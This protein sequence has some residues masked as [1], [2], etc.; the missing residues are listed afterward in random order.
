MARVVKYKGH[1]E[2]A[3]K[4]MPLEE[5]IELIPSRAR[6]L[7]KR[8]ERA[9]LDDYGSQQLKKLY[10]KAR[11]V[12]AEN[13]E[14]VMKTHAREAG[15]IN[16]W[17]GLKFGVHNGKIFVPVEVTIDKLGHRLGE[18]SHGTRRVA[19]SGAGVGATRGS[20]FVPLK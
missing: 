11:K 14:T 7:L 9:K 17:L 4:V 16:D 10:K 6:R 1:D 13:P 5:F 12:Q 19:H 18:Y 2:A 8:L 3:L 20:K 15:I